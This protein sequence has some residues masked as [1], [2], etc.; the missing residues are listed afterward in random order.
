VADTDNPYKYDYDEASAETKPSRQGVDVFTL[1]VGIATLLISGYVLSDGASWLPMFDFRWVLAGGAV[2][3][4][5]LMLG[6]SFRGGRK[7]GRKN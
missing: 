2:L 3:V 7:S 4:G 6:S 1:I 5:V